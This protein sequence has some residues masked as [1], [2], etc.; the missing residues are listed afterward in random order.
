[1]S[2]IDYTTNELVSGQTRILVPV[3]RRRV[4]YQKYL[5]KTD[6]RTGETSI[7]Y[8]GEPT[9]GWEI[10]REVPTT[11]DKEELLRTQYEN[12]FEA[13]KKL[14]L[15]KVPPKPFVKYRDDRNDGD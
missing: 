2:F 11:Q 7:L 12:S 5:E 8:V 1:M 15:V 13:E 14:V 10:S 9:T 3:M 6:R 4:E